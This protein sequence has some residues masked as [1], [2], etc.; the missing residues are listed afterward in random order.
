MTSNV[1]TSSPLY[2]G[3]AMTNHRVVSF[4]PRHAKSGD[5]ARWREPIRRGDP[6]ILLSLAKFER[7]NREDDYRQRMIMNAL[8]FIVLLA[9]IVIGVCLAVNIN[10]QHHALAPSYRSIDTDVG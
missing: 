6:G 8:A 10:D 9:L 7:D 1:A 4:R 2:R 5:T 3:Q